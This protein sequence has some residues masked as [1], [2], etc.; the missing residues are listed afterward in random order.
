MAAQVKGEDAGGLGAEVAARSVQDGLHG[1]AL[2]DANE[3]R[4]G[5]GD[6]ELCRRLTGCNGGVQQFRQ[7][8]AVALQENAELALEGRIDGLLQV[9]KDQ[10]RHARAFADEIDVR[11]EDA[12]EGVERGTG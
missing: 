5:R 4:G 9:V 1:Q 8:L 11:G 6:V 10:A 3:H 12:G 2:D 7:Q